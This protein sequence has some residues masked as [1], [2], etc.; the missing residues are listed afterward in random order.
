[1]CKLEDMEWWY[2]SEKYPVTQENTMRL[3][4]AIKTVMRESNNLSTS[5]LYND[6][7]VFYIRTSNRISLNHFFFQNGFEELDDEPLLADLFLLF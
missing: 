1:M 7:I 3:Q 6:K 5:N 4:D 2:K